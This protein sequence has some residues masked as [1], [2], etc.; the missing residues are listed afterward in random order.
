MQDKLK[1]STGRIARL[2]A[3]K[4]TAADFIEEL[5]LATF[6]RYPTA[7]ERDVLERRLE[8]AGDKRRKV[9][10]DILWALLNHKEFLFQR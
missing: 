1:S 10:E 8:K 9:V 5:F 3:A 7:D 2:L 6:S 4:K